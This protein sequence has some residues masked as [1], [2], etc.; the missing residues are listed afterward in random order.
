MNIFSKALDNIK[1]SIPFEVLR[2]VFKDDI[3][4]WRQAPI[5]MDEIIMSKVIKARVLIDANLVGGM[6]VM[7]PLNDLPMTLVDNT[8]YL[9]TIPPERCNYKEIISVLSV[10]YLPYAGT[11]GYGGIN[12]VVPVSGSMND[13]AHAG[14]QL[15][16]SYSNMPNISTASAELVGYNTVLIRDS[17]RVTSS[18]MLRCMLAND[19]NLGNIN[20]RSHIAFANLCVLAVKAYIYNKMI[21]RMDQA[22]LSGGQELGAFKNYV[23]QLADSEE[24]YSTYLRETWSSVAFHND[25]QSFERFLRV[26]INPGL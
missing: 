17:Q 25:Q 20:P 3:T 10:G 7:V 8:G 26:Q 13:I 21:I 12:A 1:F 9:Y 6:Q 11:F 5:S 15:M 23:E 16:D 14:Q 4:H 19:S 2:A 22:F 18:Y 24:M